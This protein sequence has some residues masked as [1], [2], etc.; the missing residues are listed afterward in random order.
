MEVPSV[1]LDEVIA[2]I[3][4]VTYTLLPNGRTTICQITMDND[5]SVEGDSACVSKEKY[6]QVLGEKI[7]YQRALDKVWEKL[8]FRLAE[9]LWHEKRRRLREDG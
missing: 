7:A 3:K 2:A 1:T 6:N 8:G 4:D 5:F 9:T